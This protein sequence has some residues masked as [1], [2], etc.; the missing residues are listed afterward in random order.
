MIRLQLALSINTMNPPPPL[1]SVLI[2]WQSLKQYLIKAL[3]YQSGS[4][5]DDECD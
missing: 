1:K 5:F 2:H 4:H 3:G